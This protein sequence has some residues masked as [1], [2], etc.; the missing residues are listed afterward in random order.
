MAGPSLATFQSKILIDVIGPVGEQLPVLGGGAEQRAD[1]RHRV[2]PG[3]VGDH[4]AVARAG[5]RIDEFADDL[6]DR[7]A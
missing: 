3:D 5:Q 4:V 2:L 6:D 1:D 7:A